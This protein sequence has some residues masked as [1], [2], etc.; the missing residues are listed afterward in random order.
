M[1]HETS[2]RARGVLRGLT[3]QRVVTFLVLAFCA[4]LVFYPMFFLGAASL[5]AGDPRQIPPTEFG[6]GPF[7]SVFQ[8]NIG[9]V[10]NT[11]RIAAMAT[12]LAVPIG[13]T[14][15]WIVHRTRVP[16]RAFFAQAFVL[17]YYV[18]PLVGALA[19]ATLAAPRGGFINQMY[20]M[21]T[22]IEDGTL[23]NIHS[24]AG[25]A[26][27]MAL[28]EGAV[29]FVMISAAMR[30]MDPALEES[31]QVFGANKLMTIRKVTLPLLKPAVLGASV[32]VFA[33]MLGAFAAP[34]VLGSADRLFTI[35]TS[36]YQLVNTFPP[37]YP[38]AA[39]FGITLFAIMF[40]MMW[41]YQR[42]IRRGSFVTVSGKAFR[43]RPVEMGRLTAVLFTVCAGYFFIAILLPLGSLVMSSFQSFAT[44]DIFNAV[45]TTGNYERAIGMGPVRQ[46]LRNSVVL[47][48]A[49]ASAGVLIMG[50]LAWLIYKSPL[51]PRIGKAMEYTV[52]FPLAVPRMVF[53]LA[54]LWAWLLIPIPIY[55]TL[56]L[57]WLAYLTV[58]LPLG[59]RT[60][61]GVTLQIDK[62][63]EECARVCGAGRL[64]QMRTVTMPLLKPGLIAAW[65]LIFIA[66]VRELGA[67][68]MLQGPRSKVIGPAI[69]ESWSSSGRT[70]T[71][72]MA[73]LQIG[74]I[75]IALIIM[76]V[77]ARRGRAKA[78]LE[79]GL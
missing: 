2:T 56:W 68:I 36:I 61:A 7:R 27:V 39:A 3:A 13:F 11:V 18:T 53:G 46:A 55:G 49:T 24:A 45:W 67:S 43:P 42:T 79:G 37:D 63:L 30:S 75:A 71:A 28:F 34:L 62:S 5:N 69:V 40:I 17:P 6:L 8:A 72:A 22:G 14:L 9:I 31:S 76:F 15:A 47:G 70:L 73:L 32:F 64:H 60:I 12:V 10:W 4:G 78:S 59:V 21:V 33:E 44:A 66:S 1:L 77:V 20:R 25:I 54:L 57:L 50:Y 48:V 19:W 58:M 51:S 41:F 35:T 29:A 23:I 16:G 52:M 74:A 38:R 26:W 65:L